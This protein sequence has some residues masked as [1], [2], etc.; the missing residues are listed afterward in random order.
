MLNVLHSKFHKYLDPYRFVWYED[1]PEDKKSDLI[2]ALLKMGKGSRRLVPLK[3]NRIEIRTEVLE[4]VDRFRHAR[5]SQFVGT[6]EEIEF[7]RKI[8]VYTDR[9]R[10]VNWMLYA[11]LCELLEDKDK[12]E[13]FFKDMEFKVSID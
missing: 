4:M 2:I 1:V 7:P 12:C 11:L 5:I 8:S 10:I 3:R 6:Q 9:V 13:Q